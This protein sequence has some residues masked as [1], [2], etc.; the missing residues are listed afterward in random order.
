[1]TL[2]AT[3]QGWAE[4]AVPPLVRRTFAE[5]SEDRIAAEAGG[6]TFFVL[7]ALFPAIASIVSLYGLVADRASIGHVVDALTPYLP[8]GAISVLD[9]ELHRLLMEKPA[10]LNFGFY[11]GLVVA[12][13]GASGGI[14]ALIEALNVAFETKETRSFLR[15]TGNALLFTAAAIAVTVGA[16]YLT[17]VLPKAVGRFGGAR[18]LEPV[19][20]VLRWPTA[21]LVVTLMFELIYRIG[22]NRP[23]TRPTWISWGSAIGGALWIL[24]TL[25]FS[26]YVQNFG[27]YDRVYGNLGAAVG[28]LTWI[29][30]S[31]MILLGGAELDCE[32][33]R[34][35]RTDAPDRL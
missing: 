18:I 25:A 13:W 12:L 9:T 17:V 21:W 22:P 31:L 30:I 15:L 32:L 16:V 11:G 2:L 26:W 7:L 28:F 35:K 23:L 6:V 29:W 24:S 8:G 4:A 20:A 14:G 1:M 27:S 3:L 10:K 33:E 19:L 5:F 34:R